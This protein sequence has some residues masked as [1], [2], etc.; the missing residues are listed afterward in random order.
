MKVLLV[1]PF[2]PYAQARHAGGEFVYN[3]VTGL[4]AR[5]QVSLVS[6]V[7]PGEERWVDELSPY[8]HALETVPAPKT[9]WGRARYAP[10]LLTSPLSAVAGASQQMAAAIERVLSRDH[11]DVVQIEYSQL[12]QFVRLCNGSATVL[13][14]HD[15]FSVPAY[16]RYCLAS[17]GL[18]KLHWWF[19]WRKRLLYERRAHQRFDCMFVRS[20]LDKKTVLAASP[21]GKVAIVPH[22][23][24]DEFFDIPLCRPPVRRILFVGAMNRPENQDAILF[25]SRDILPRIRQQ[26]PDVRLDI[27]GT[28]PSERIRA[29]GRDQ[30][31]TVT[32]F[33]PS[34]QEYYERSS[35]C[36]APIRVGG[37][38]IV[39]ILNG[40]AAGRPVVSTS[41][42][43]EGVGA[44]AGQEICVADAPEQFAEQVVRLFT[45][46]R[47]WHEIARG[48]RTFARRRPDWNTIVERTFGIYETLVH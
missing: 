32:G 37:G 43:N 4:S 27:V 30:G 34:L 35:I 7:L 6:K 24:R 15:V 40:M 1:S 36:I 8:C 17:S 22:G 39:K 3:L 46:P 19:E 45:D 10:M 26:L 18:A 13:D 38:T 41:I 31:I 14:E 20:Q 5:C 25:F 16:R 28:A 23:C 12:A 33:V 29:L 21:R 2:L 9:F 44:A 48:G 42:G 47:R 11:Y